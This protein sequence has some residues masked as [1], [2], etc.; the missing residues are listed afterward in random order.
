M[1]IQNSLLEDSSIVLNMNKR[2]ESPIINVENRKEFERLFL[3]FPFLVKTKISTKIIRVLL[4][5]PLNFLYRILHKISY[6]LNMK[7]YYN[8]SLI[9]GLKI[10]FD[11]RRGERYIKAFFEREK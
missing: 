11:I 8:I 10:F 1:A 7:R 4:K 5:L 2:P 6:F 9:S 3:L